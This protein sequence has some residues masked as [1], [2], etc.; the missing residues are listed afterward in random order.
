MSRWDTLIQVDQSKMSPEMHLLYIF[1][2]KIKMQ[3]IVVVDGAVLRNC[4]WCSCLHCM[5][6]HARAQSE[7]KKNSR[8]LFN[9]MFR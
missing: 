9:D 4:R 6:T 7:N 1:I 3:I 5:H 8:K 2:K